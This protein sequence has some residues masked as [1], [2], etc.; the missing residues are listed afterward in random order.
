MDVAAFQI[1]RRPVSNASW[2]GFSEGGGYERREWW[3]DEGWAWKQE[4][5]ITHH[6]QMAAGDSAG[7]RLPRQLVRG[8]R[9]RQSAR[10][11]P[12]QRGRVGEGGEEGA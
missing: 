5:D 12:A 7:A 1:A 9:L 3:S 4:Y 2:M 10:R 8:R 11:A 6:P